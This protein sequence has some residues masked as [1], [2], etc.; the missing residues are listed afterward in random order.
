[1][2]NRLVRWITYNLIFASLPLI[3]S[4]LLRHLVDKLTL[5]ALANSP[6]ILFFSL[7]ISATALGDLGEIKPPSHWE[8]LFKIFW[9][10]LLLGAIGSAIL[11]GAFLFDSII[12]P[13]SPVFRLRLLTFSMWMTA[14]YFVLS[15]AVEVIIGRLEVQK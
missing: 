2:A 11:Y 12:G 10:A 3:S 13:Q 6:E 4:L 8:I 9:S 5:D 1:M 14:A 15:T 7:M